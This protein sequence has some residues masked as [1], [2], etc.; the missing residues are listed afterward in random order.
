M[1]TLCVVLLCAS[2][3]GCIFSSVSEIRAKPIARSAELTGT[4]DQLSHCMLREIHTREITDDL[5]FEPDAA[6]ASWRLI[7]I[8]RIQMF[9]ATANAHLDI[10]FLPLNH[11]RSR[12]EIREGAL[13]GSRYHKK[14]WPV[15]EQCSRQAAHADAPPQST[16]PTAP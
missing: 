14:V 4:P 8:N 11:N 1:R 16:V 9:K 10:L 15:I 3:S 2:L 12:V 6:T 5:L 7:L 13:T